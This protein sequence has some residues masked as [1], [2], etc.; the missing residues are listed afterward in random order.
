MVGITRNNPQRSRRRGLTTIEYTGVYV[1]YLHKYY[2]IF[3]LIFIILISD[4]IIITYLF[5]SLSRGNI[6]IVC[7]QRFDKDRPEVRGRCSYHS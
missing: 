5:L 1:L 4:I 2:S 6:G 7:F 3:S